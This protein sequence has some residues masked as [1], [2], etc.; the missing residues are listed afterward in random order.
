MIHLIIHDI[1][2]S[3]ATNEPFSFF[4]KRTHQII[5]TNEFYFNNKMSATINSLM[6]FNCNFKLNGKKEWKKKMIELKLI[7]DTSKFKPKVVGTFKIDL[8]EIQRKDVINSKLTL[9]RSSIGVITLN[10][11]LSSGDHIKHVS[12]DSLH[13]SNHISFPGKKMK[14][15]VKISNLTM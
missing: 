14:T 13:K 2:A 11:T 15:Q 4:V 1:T 7:K 6:K 8:S 12:I 3:N 5:E 9:M 10:I